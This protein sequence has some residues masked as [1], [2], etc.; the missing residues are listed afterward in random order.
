MNIGINLLIWKKIKS[1]SDG[2]KDKF[3]ESLY[4]SF[5]DSMNETH[6]KQLIWDEFLGRKR[7][8]GKIYYCPKLIRRVNI[9]LKHRGLLNSYNNKSKS[10]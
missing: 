10:T 9:R 6:R 5:N 7:V 4:K 8:K 1:M 2:E 3:I